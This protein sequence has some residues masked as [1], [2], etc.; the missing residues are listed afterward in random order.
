MSGLVWACCSAGRSDLLVKKTLSTLARGNFS[1]SLYVIVPSDELQTYQAAVA[2]API[3]CILLHCG[4]GLVRQR[5]HFRSMMLPGTEI[6]WIDDDIEAIKIR[7]PS[8]LEHARNLDALAEFV[9]NSMAAHPDKPRLAGVYPMTNALFQKASV[10]SRYAYV[11]GALYFQVHDDT[12]P[13]PDEDEM[14]D[15]ARCLGEH[16]V[17]RPV[18]RFNWIGIQTQYWKN[19]GGLQTLRTDAKRAAA[20]KRLAELYSPL[21]KVMTRR[22]GKPDLK[23]I[24]PTEYW[25][26]GT[27]DSDSAL[28]ESTPVPPTDEVPPL[29]PSEQYDPSGQE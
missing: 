21:V 1:G 20:V 9:F 29:E 7:T 27:P 4:R 16:A 12:D 2:S 25:E 18:L 17:G 6:V 14:E 3:H 5:A 15:W 13:E 19:P 24:K 22:N 26:G 23:F 28:P 10:A 8:G 11:V